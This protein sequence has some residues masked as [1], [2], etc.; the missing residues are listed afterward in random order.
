MDVGSLRLIRCVLQNYKSLKHVE[1]T[2][3]NRLTVLMGRNN[4]GKSNLLD[5]F[6]FLGDA[7]HGFQS[8]LESRGGSLSEITYR[9]DPGRAIEIRLDFS[10]AE[11]ARA[12][13]ISDLFAENSSV[14]LDSV[15]ATEFLS[16][17]ILRVSIHRERICDELLVSNFT[18]NSA[19]SLIFQHKGTPKRME[20]AAGNL[21]ELCRTHS[22]DLPCA[23]RPLEVKANDP[24][25]FRLYLGRPEPK[26]PDL[27]AE[28]PVALEIAELVHEKFALL[29][30]IDPLRNLPVRA[31]IRGDTTILPNASN[32]PD[33]LH[34]V[35]NNRPKQFRRIET[36][37]CKLVPHL[38]RL[39][40]PTEQNAATLGVIDRQEEDLVYTMSQMSFGTR[41]AIAIIAKVV[42][43]PPGTWLC[44]EEPETYLHPKAQISLFQ[45]L[46]DEAAD[47]E[48]FLAT[49]STPIAASTPLQS[50]VIVER[51]GENA[52]AV[53]PVTEETAAQVIEQL[54]VKPSFSFEADAIVFVEDPDHIPIYEAWARKFPFHIKIQFLDAEG[55]DTL[56]YFANTRIAASRFVHTLVYVVFD[57]KSTRDETRSKVRERLLGHLQL[58]PEQV[59]TLD[60][61]EV[62]GHLF[63]AKAMQR[64]FHAIELSQEE[65]ESR[66][67]A[68]R[69][70][71]NPKEFLAGLFS[72][73]ELGGYEGR[74]GARIA[75]AMDSIP[76]LI[77][78]LFQRIDTSSK[79]FWKI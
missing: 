7:S 1:L 64:A 25:A 42:L 41:S 9:K 49:H 47:K 55:A 17:A 31:P 28:C 44:I 73:L 54:G 11:E 61:D 6:N 69:Q 52:T 39:F 79:P 18:P 34:W 23:A 76:P 15:L 59:L 45:F 38:G 57:G 37:V 75:D 58:P 26:N 60:L 12:K 27:L 71:P 8:A 21:D 35:Y 24:G 68:R 19:P 67:N 13:F 29:Q 50:L 48:I 22:T 53:T 56:H 32:L 5:C 66:L 77:A 40:T 3:L 51:D 43:A 63:D 10:L 30:W 20:L 33:V 2:R 16:T 62:E 78:D 36:E 72:E 74:M 14:S 4:A 70:N 46:R 65:L